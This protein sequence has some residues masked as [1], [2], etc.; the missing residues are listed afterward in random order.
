MSFQKSL[1]LA[2]AASAL[3]VAALSAPAAIARVAAPPLSKV[4]ARSAARSVAWE[5]A[6]RNP[7][8]NSVKIEGCERRERDRFLCTA[9]DRGATSELRT[10]C[11]VRIAVR[12]RADRPE[13]SLRG[14][15]CQNE[16]L[17]LLRAPQA[18]AAILPEAEALGGPEARIVFIGRQERAVIA[19]SVG[20]TVKPPTASAEELCVAKILARL[21]ATGDIEVQVGAPR[22]LPI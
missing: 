16:R 20:W 21:L 10:T 12:L 22:C 6:R 9:V 3:S 11:E 18:L 5:V 17:L 2:L 15:S 8:V 1:A 14:V 13:A 4:R 19:A 7:S